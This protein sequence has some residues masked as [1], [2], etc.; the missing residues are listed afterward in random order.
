MISIPLM[1]MLIESLVPNA[2]VMQY[3][4]VLVGGSGQF[5]PLSRN[6]EAG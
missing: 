4:G 6:L 5:A 3:S 1:E 2:T